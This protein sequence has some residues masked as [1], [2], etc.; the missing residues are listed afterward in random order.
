VQVDCGRQLQGSNC[1]VHHGHAAHWCERKQPCSCS[2][3][4]CSTCSGASAQ[5]ENNFPSLQQRRLYWIES[6]LDP[7]SSR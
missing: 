4:Q 7:P 2:A 5:R 1:C 3:V 6:M